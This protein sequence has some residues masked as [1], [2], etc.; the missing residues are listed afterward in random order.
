MHAGGIDDGSIEGE[1]SS[2]A[3]DRITR[4]FD[5]EDEDA[6]PLVKLQP[7][8]VCPPLI[9]LSRPG[10]ALEAAGYSLGVLINVDK[11]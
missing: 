2:Q 7:T 1:S 10:A 3:F 9:A 5:V 8:L 6:E 11:C 4:Q